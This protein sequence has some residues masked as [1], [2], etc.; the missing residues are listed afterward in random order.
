MNHFTDQYIIHEPLSK[1]Q[2]FADRFGEDLFTPTSELKYPLLSILCPE[3][4]ILCSVIHVYYLPNI[5][6]NH[7]KHTNITLQYR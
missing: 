5:T 6:D 3:F 1:P 2:L 7:D 4:S